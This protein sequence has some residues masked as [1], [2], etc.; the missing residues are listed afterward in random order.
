MKPINLLFILVL[1]ASFS[2][3]AKPLPSGIFTIAIPAGKHQLEGTV[4]LI[5][6]EGKSR[7]HIR[8]EMPTPINFALNE[9]KRSGDR[10]TYLASSP[11]LQVVIS[12]NSEN[13]SIMGD[14]ML[15]RN[16]SFSF[17]GGRQPEETE[18]LQQLFSSRKP[19]FAHDSLG[20][21]FPAIIKTEDYL[22][23]STY[24]Q[25][26]GHQ[27]L[28]ESHRVDGKWKA[29]QKLPFSGK[30]SDRAPAF[31]PAGEWLYFGS[32]RPMDDQDASNDD[33]NLWRVKRSKNGS[34]GKPQP[35]KG[36]NSAA[37]DYQPCVTNDG[38]YFSSDREGG[39]G[40]QDIY[41]AK[42]Q[43]GKFEGP[44]N[45]GEG[46]NSEQGDMSAWVIPNGQKMVLST[47]KPE[48]QGNDDLFLFEQKGG[49]WVLVRNLGEDIN[50][51]ANEYGG[52][53]S[54]DGKWLYYTSDVVA[55]AKIYK[56][57]LK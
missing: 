3:H 47:V 43:N 39:F 50:T 27:T 9:W 7:G 13:D 18:R 41:F 22:V 10:C 32:K 20:C 1:L 2:I 48:G 46:V 40:G 23:F 54:A 36:I 28:M 15:S 19:V 14:L 57:R 42:G 30:G 4:T 52:F 35:V 6:A 45:L 56:A 37:N 51:F 34:W 12:F 55:P 53:I 33:Y 16:R 49:K 5:N 11:A 24:N 38:I 44:T 31:D 21:A 17:K 29:P 25:D 26:F 8:I